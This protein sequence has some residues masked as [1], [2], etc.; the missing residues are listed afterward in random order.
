MW[1]LATFGVDELETCAADLRGLGGDAGSME[2]VAERVVATLYD[3]LV[4]PDGTRSTALVRLYITHRFRG[5]DAGLR[6]FAGSAAGDQQLDDDVPCLTLLAT[7]GSD[8]A[9]CDRRR[10]VLHQAIPLPS[11][12]AVRR[13]PM[14]SGL[15]DDLGVA[16]DDLLRSPGPLDALE[17]HHR[18]Y[19]LFFVPEAAGSEWVPAQDFV[20]E[21]G[22]RSV[23]GIGGALPS[24]E[25][26]A[27]VLFT[28]VA[29]PAAA[30]DLFRSLAP[31]VKASIVPVTYRVFG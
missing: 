12:E 4:E 10:S 26:F 25:V 17:L 20:R 8:P 2:E 23:L 11:P 18:S 28:R 3:G 6:A 14:V 15:F 22:I 31:A 24:G 16:L 21:H 1:S 5:L 29:V 13:L 9:W 30:A 19:D 27:V 7:R